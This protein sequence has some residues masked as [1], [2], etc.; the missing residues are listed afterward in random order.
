MGHNNSWDGSLELQAMRN[1]YFYLLLLVTLVTLMSPVAGAR[2][3]V[4]FN[5]EICPL[6]SKQCIACHGPDDGDRQADLRL[7]TFEG[8]TEYAIVPGDPGS[9]DLIDRITTDDDDIR[10]RTRPATA[11]VKEGYCCGRPRA[12]WM[13]LWVRALTSVS[14]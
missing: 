11:S 7:D 8:A 4:D 10:M 13:R 12:A 14:P 3:P 5:L 1:L 6:L 2:E 9:S